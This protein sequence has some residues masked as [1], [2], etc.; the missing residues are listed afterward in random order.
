MNFEKSLKKGLS[1]FKSRTF[2]TG[3]EWADK[4]YYLSEESSSS[5][6]KWTTLPYQKAILDLM[7]DDRCEEINFKKSRRVGYTEMLKAAIGYFVEFR[8]RNIAIWFPN[9]KIAHNFSSDAIDNLIRDCQ[10]FGMCFKGEYGVKSKYNSIEKK[11]FNSCV[12]DIRGGTSPANYD[13]ITKQVALYDEC[14]RF[15]VDI[16]G[17][18]NCF[19]LGDGRLDD[20]SFPKSIR[21]STPGSKEFSVIE[22]AV[23]NSDIIL[24]RYVECPYCGEHQVLRKKNLN[25]DTAEFICEYC[26]KS[27]KYAKYRQMDRNGF[28]ASANKEIIYD[29]KNRYF[30]KDGK[31]LKNFPR[32]I[33]FKIWCAYSYLKP[34]SFF[35]EKWK[36]ASERSKTGDIT[37][38]KTAVNQLL[39]ETWVEEGEEQDVLAVMSLRSNYNC[40]KGI[41][42]AVEVITVGADVQGGKNARVEMEFLGFDKEGNHIS[43]D[44][45][46]IN[47]DFNDDSMFKKI[48]EQLSRNFKTVSGREIFVSAAFMD[49]GYL[50]DR[51][52]KYCA[53][54]RRYNI[55]PT[56][57]VNTGG[58][59][60]KGKWVGDQKTKTK[61]VLRT[62]NVDDCK[63]LVYNRLTN[64]RC[65]FP[66]NY[67]D[68]Y[69]EQLTNERK[70]VNKVK[71]RAVGYKWQVIKSGLGNEP[72]DC[73][74]YAIGAFNY[75]NPNFI[76]S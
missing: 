51:V 33:G 7:T 42:E 68:L 23:E 35:C 8:K 48:D 24:E 60:N 6:G 18:G 21:G 63:D 12:L 53:P 66:D 49:S 17:F 40:L 26:M 47:G 3:S 70:V 55:F 74:C 44:Y 16:G 54:R 30:V 65:L 73:R 25:I 75:I 41:P 69:F 67:G 15:P 59:P 11:I 1:A 5:A 29:E 27:I 62:I 52:Y 9:E 46:V 4:Y 22:P 76:H 34:W 14:D 45:V 37:L 13:A 50:T 32:S 56:K 31:R 71:G 2:I 28:W 19:E 61:C 58:I 57:G 10:I 39:G 38:L 20:A 43:C 36:T 64:K 72:L